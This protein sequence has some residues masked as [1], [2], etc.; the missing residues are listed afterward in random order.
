M[1]SLVAMIL[2]TYIKNISAQILLFTRFL[3]P[4]FVGGCL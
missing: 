1:S 2:F 4:G 3:W